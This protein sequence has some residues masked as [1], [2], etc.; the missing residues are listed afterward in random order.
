[1]GLTLLNEPPRR[2]RL[3]DSSI[4]SMSAELIGDKEKRLAFEGIKGTSP[5]TSSIRSR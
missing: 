5:R 2:T 3:L 4:N 1:M